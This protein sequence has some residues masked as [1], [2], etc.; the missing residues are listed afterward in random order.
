MCFSSVTN[1]VHMQELLWKLQHVHAFAFS[2]IFRFAFKFSLY[3][4]LW[5]P[6]RYDP[7]IFSGSNGIWNAR[8]VSAVLNHAFRFSFLAFSSTCGFGTLLLPGQSLNWLFI[9]TVTSLDASRVCRYHSLT[10]FTCRYSLTCDTFTFYCTLSPF[11]F[12]YFLLMN[13]RPVEISI[14]FTV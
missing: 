13:I 11:Y 5:H 3:V 6:I 7:R 12:R 14:Q 9:I 1:T 8:R 4:R 2:G 10:K